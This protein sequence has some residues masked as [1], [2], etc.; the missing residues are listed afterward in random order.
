MRAPQLSTRLGNEWTRSG[1]LPPVL[2]GL[3]PPP[4]AVRGPHSLGERRLCFWIIEAFFL[5]AFLL[6]H[7]R[8]DVWN[9]WRNGERVTG[10]VVDLEYADEKIS[11]MAIRDPATERRI[12]VYPRFQPPDKERGD[13]ATVVVMPGDPRKVATPAD[14]NL[15]LGCWGVAPL[16]AVWWPLRCWRRRGMLAV[17]DWV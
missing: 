6:L 12:T 9:W 13:M 7:L 17:G 2:P 1:A 8:A 14:L 10:V 11:E 3:P 5:C 16:L 15:Y 4:A